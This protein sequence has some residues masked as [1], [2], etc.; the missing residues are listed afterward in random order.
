MTGGLGSRREKCGR[1]MQWCMQ[2]CLGWKGHIHK[3]TYTTAHNLKGRC[4]NMLLQPT[5]CGK[6]RWRFQSSVCDHKP[7]IA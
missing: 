7:H 3:G 6:R 5:S 1:V 2:G 4:V